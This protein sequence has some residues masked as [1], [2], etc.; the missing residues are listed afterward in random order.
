MTNK[1]RTARSLQPLGC[2]VI[3][4]KVA[5]SYSAYMC[6]TH[7]FDHQCDGRDAGKRLAAAGFNW[8]R[9]AE[10][11][12]KNYNDSG[13]VVRGWMNSQGHRDNILKRG[14]TEIGVGDH[15]CNDGSRY[16][17]MVLVDAYDGF[18]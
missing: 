3:A 8:Q 2:N 13:S 18:N 12:A 16:W 15:Q 14:I 17:T 9:F 5:K 10:N 11:I 4:N 6:R 7:C 1:E